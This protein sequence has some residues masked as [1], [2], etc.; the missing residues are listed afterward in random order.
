M[1]TDLF[2]LHFSLYFANSIQKEGRTGRSKHRLFVYLCE[3]YKPLEDKKA[4]NTPIYYVF[5]YV[6]L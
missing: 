6:V 4:K 2:V 5:I 1:N 3:M